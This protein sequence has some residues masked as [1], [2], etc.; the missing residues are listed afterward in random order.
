[1]DKFDFETTFGY[2]KEMP[3]KLQNEALDE[4]SKQ[5]SNMNSA[6]SYSGGKNFSTHKPYM[7]RGQN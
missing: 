4:G 5:L 3:K 7:S 1:M 6:I 2:T